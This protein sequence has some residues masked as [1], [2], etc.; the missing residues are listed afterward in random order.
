MNDSF[1]DSG[2]GFKDVKH[3][4]EQHYS[5][6]SSLIGTV[7]VAVWWVFS[8]LILKPKINDI[9]TWKYLYLL[10]PNVNFCRPSF[11]DPIRFIIQSIWLIVL[12]VIKFISIFSY[13]VK[14]LQKSMVA[15]QSLVSSQYAELSRQ[16]IEF[17]SLKGQTTK[18]E[19]P[20]ARLGYT[21]YTLVVGALFV[22][23]V[24]LF[25]T[26]PLTLEQHTICVM[27]LTVI[28]FGLRSLPGKISLLV[29]MALSATVSSRYIW[30]RLN[31][32]INW[33]D[34]LSTV[35][36]LV[37]LGAEIYA[38]IVLLLGYF[39]NAWPLDRKP[40][41]LDSI[42][43]TWPTVD[44]FI[45]TYNEPLDVV[46]ATVFAAQGIDWPKDKL[47][48]YILDDGKRIEFKKFAQLANVGYLTRSTND[49]AKAGNINHALQCTSGEYVAIFDCDH[50]PTRAFLQL[51][52]GLF[53]EDKKLALIQTPH[54]FFSPDPFERNLN[55]FRTVPNEGNLFY[56][57][58]QDGND[59]WD[60]AFF[61]GSCAILKREP[62]LEVGGIAVETVTEDAHTS[63]RLHRLGY[64]SA[65]LKQ[66][67]SAGLA[68]ETLSAHIGQRIRWA[69][70][71]AQI[72]RIDNPLLGKG[73]NWRQRFCYL[74]A[75]LHFLSGIPRIIFLLAPLGYLVLGANVIDTSALALLAYVVPHMVITAI[76]NSKIQGRY[77]YSFWGEVYETVLAW[78]IARPTT[79]A[80]FAPHK[81][82]FN[83]TAK[84]GL[85]PS[86]HFDWSISTPYLIFMLLNV[87]GVFV[88]IWKVDLQDY[89]L[90]ATI[91]VNL[92]WTSYNLLIIGAAIAIAQESKQV[93]KDH[94]VGIS[95]PVQ[96]RTRGGYR[97]QSELLDFSLSGAKLQLHS[98]LVRQYSLDAGDT[99]ILTLERGLG[100]SSFSASIVALEADSCRLKFETM[101]LAKQ[102]EFVQCTFARAD[103]WSRWQKGYRPDQPFNSLRQIL[104]AGSVGYYQLTKNIF[105]IKLGQYQ[106]LRA[107]AKLIVS[108]KP[109]SILKEH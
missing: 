33:H 17:E 53:S 62:L 24:F 81:G 36:G 41:P 78:Y 109:H 94:R 37:L 13:L 68:T 18:A 43:E 74:N 71:M 95:I 28:A 27:T 60:A 49:H 22:S 4:Y 54:H 9:F 55:N 108:L 11:I 14:W 8:K 1:R 25:V 77:R 79:V 93:R 56:G 58:V 105:N 104:E 3:K 82:K 38:W 83:V 23:I 63:L 5:C 32:T 72:F 88:G 15:A 102:V 80:L 50:I 47:K 10:Y 99:L 76:T 65:Y 19:T 7:I 86:S 66:P 6:E 16:I 46:R 92:A 98:N 84:G 12:I 31:E 29:M 107:T 87:I 48:I 34:T 90:T 21:L 69:R 106:P 51:T 73:L 103:L 70:G 42:I 101:S 30:W 89:A 100:R 67:L 2:L 39:Q 44:I 57:L 75:M 20:T 85:I 26:V 61:C 64:R 40:A 97:L 52:M 96:V 59:L 35:L 45:P 91:A